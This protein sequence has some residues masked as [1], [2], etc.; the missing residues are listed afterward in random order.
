RQGG[1]HTERF[2]SRFVK[3]STTVPAQWMQEF[4]DL[5]PEMVAAARG[6][7]DVGAQF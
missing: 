6:I 2:A 5:L 1:Y 7:N 3:V 4:C